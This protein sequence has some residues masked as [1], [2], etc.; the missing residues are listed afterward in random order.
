MRHDVRM[1]YQQVVLLRSC[2]RRCSVNSLRMLRLH[3]GQVCCSSSQGSTQSLWY[4]WRHGSTRRHWD[5]NKTPPQFLLNHCRISTSVTVFKHHLG[6]N[7]GV[8]ADLVVVE[9][10]QTDGTII[11]LYRLRRVPPEFGLTVHFGLQRRHSLQNIL[12]RE[13]LKHTAQ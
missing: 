3:R 6:L 1:K 9:R 11:C 5:D 4:S 8:L 12:F 10:L 13:E 7:Q 2:T